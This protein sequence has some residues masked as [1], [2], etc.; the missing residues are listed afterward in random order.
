VPRLPRLRALAAAAVLVGAL[1]LGAVVAT[2][3]PASAAACTAR[4][5]PDYTRD[6]SAV[7]TGTV[8]GTDGTPRTDGQPGQ[9]FA[10]DV[11]VERVYKG[12]V[13]SDEAQVQTDKLPASTQ[14]CTLGRLSTGATY[15]FFVT[16]SGEPWVAPGA[17]GTQ[18]ATTDLVS[19]VEATLGTGRAP[20]TPA[21]ETATFR[22]LDVDDP[23]AL[24]RLAAPGVA[25][26]IIG[27]LGLLLVGRLGRRS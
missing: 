22:Q 20:V 19:Q 11:S 16:G 23:T 9:V 27:L 13:E 5:V 6:A 4:T 3:A 24:S 8:T 17:G 15:V 26:V 1:P 14:Q 25:L 2:G 7:F 21:A 10:T 18:V 12:A